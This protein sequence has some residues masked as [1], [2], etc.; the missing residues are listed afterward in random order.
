MHSERAA[1]GLSWFCRRHGAGIPTE[2]TR[3]GAK[4]ALVT[5]GEREVAIL[6]MTRRFNLIRSNLAEQDRFSIWRR[7]APWRRRL[8]G[9]CAGAFS[10]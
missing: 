1:G 8:L 10:G 4:R 6:H 5:I 2:P 9:H 3:A 7:F